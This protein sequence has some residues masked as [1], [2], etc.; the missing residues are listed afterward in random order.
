MKKFLTILLIITASIAHAQIDSTARFSLLTCSPLSE[1]YATFGHT[2]LRYQ[3]PAENTDIVFNYG[4]FSFDDNFLFNFVKGNTY[5]ELGVQR[6]EHFFERSAEDGQGII[7]QKLNLTPEEVEYMYELLRI[8]YE[9]QNR[10]YLYNFFY[11]NCATRVRDIFVTMF[12]DTS[13]AE[14]LQWRGIPET[15]FTNGLW[16]A[17]WISAMHNHLET[18]PQPTFRSLIHVYTARN[19]W[20]QNGIALG[21][22]TPADRTVTEF[23]S[24]F[25]PD[26]LFLYAQE[27]YIVSDGIGKERKLVRETN[28][29][30]GDSLSLIDEFMWLTPNLVFWFLAIIFIGIAFIEYRTK[31]HLYWLDSLLYFKLGVLGI[32]VWFLSFFS[33]HPAVFPNIH[34][35]WAS[36]LHI[37]FA[38]LW[39]VP[40]MRKYL[41]WYVKLYAVIFAVMIVLF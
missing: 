23:E 18:T 8:N 21:L 15:S 28:V 39:L 3:N 40:R 31:K 35:L 10:K 36:P 37:V 41:Q 34:V 25:L 4:I 11:D 5:Y 2:A 7:E 17:G 19:P 9:P 32:L 6:F 38:V 16:G 13:F 14:T 33:V 29:L 1:V 26:C 12:A 30:L 24:M 22:G 20:L 27:A